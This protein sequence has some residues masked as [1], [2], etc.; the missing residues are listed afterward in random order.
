MFTDKKTLDRRV[1]KVFGA[2]KGLKNIIIAN[3]DSEDPNFIYMT[4]LVGGLFEGSLLLV[5][6]SGV[7]LYTSPLE[8]E[9]AKEQLKNGIKIV[10]MD[11]KEK[12][13]LLK[14]TDGG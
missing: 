11:K 8:Y 9:L 6:E 5:T 4:D 3:T 2:T 14:K 10:N 13:E 7:T 12:V 1:E